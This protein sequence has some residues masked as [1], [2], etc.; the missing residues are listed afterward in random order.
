[1]SH[2]IRTP[3]TGMLGMLELLSLTFL[4]N[5]QRDTLDAAWDSG[6]GL[7]RI[8]SDIL[9]WSKIEEGK[10]EISPRPTSIEQLLKD[11]VNAYSRTASAKALLLWQHADSRLASAYMI[12]PLRLS[13]VLNN[14]VSN[15]IK[16]TKVGEIE[17]R[18]ELLEHLDSADRVCFSV[19]DTGEGIAGEVQEQL[20]QRYR[21]GS[22][23]TARIYGGTGLGLSI[24]KRLADLMDGR[25]ALKSE[26]G[27]GSVFSITLI[28]PVSGLPGEPVNG[29][30]PEVRQR[31]VQP[32]FTDDADSPLVL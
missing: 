30:Y 4:D 21:Q 16:F 24:C 28:L 27:Q 1:M 11:V 14:F 7:L 18:A 3:L 17:V 26:P 2:E 20:F 13:Q 19:R 23:D 5:E 6:R 8:V 15:A 29:R 25:V 10:L 32:L 31:E 12:D 9:D 22:S